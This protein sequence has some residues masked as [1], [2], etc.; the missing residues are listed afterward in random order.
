[1]GVARICPTI[2]ERSTVKPKNDAV[3]KWLRTSIEAGKQ[4]GCLHLPIIDP[5]Q[6]L[7]ATIAENA[8]GLRLVAATGDEYEKP[9]E[10]LEPLPGNEG[11]G[12]VDRS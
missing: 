2:Y 5:P 1:M 7:S 4:S 11:T 9:P 8:P 10:P 12:G 6:D 3:K